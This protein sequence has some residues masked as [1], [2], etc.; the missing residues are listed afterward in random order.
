[1]TLWLPVCRDY[2]LDAGEDA[3]ASEQA[4]ST[5]ASSTGGSLHVPIAPKAP[6]RL[7]PVDPLPANLSQQVHHQDPAAFV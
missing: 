5:G 3:A 1:M 2:K 7:L 6:L 4:A